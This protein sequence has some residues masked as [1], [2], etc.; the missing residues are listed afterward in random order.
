M[1]ITTSR[2]IMPMRRDTSRMARTTTTLGGFPQTAPPKREKEKEKSKKERRIRGEQPN[3]AHEQ[4]VSHPVLSKVNTPEI[5]SMS[6][7]VFITRM[8]PLMV[9]AQMDPCKEGG[10]DREQRTNTK[11]QAQQTKT[12]KQT[13]QQQRGAHRQGEIES[14]NK[15]H[16]RAEERKEPRTQTPRF[17]RN[18]FRMVELTMRTRG[19]RAK[20]SWIDRTTCDATSAI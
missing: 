6:S 19:M 16:K 7:Q 11:A 2:K 4:V 5:P 8:I 18:R 12:N 13:R 10:G 9:H 14:K 17:K 1:V 20:G 15:R 3:Q